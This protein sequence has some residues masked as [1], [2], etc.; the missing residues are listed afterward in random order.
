MRR[1]HFSSNRVGRR[2]VVRSVALIVCTVLLANIAIAVPLKAQAAATTTCNC[3]VWRLDDIQ[4]NF[5]DTVQ[6]A[7]IDHFIANHQ[8][9]GAVAIMNAVGN[10]TTI[11]NEVKKGL[12]NGTL[13]IGSHAWDHVD[14]TQLPAAT[15]QDTLQKSK[16]KMIQ[17]WGVTPNLF[18]PPFNAYNN[19]TLATLQSLGFKVIS[20]EF[21][22]E[23]PS[24]YDPNNPNASSNLIYKAIPNSDLKD[25]HGL[26]H[27]PQAIGFYTYGSS[28]NSTA[29][30]VKTPVTTI[31]SKIDSTIATY[32][33]A[34]VTLHPDEFAVNFENGVAQ[35]QVSATAMADLDTLFNYVNGKGYTSKTFSEVID[36]GSISPPPDTTPPSTPQ[37]ASPIDNFKAVIGSSSGGAL[38]TFGWNKATDPDSPNVSYELLVAS[39]SNFTTGSI[40]I[41]KTGLTVLSYTLAIKSESLPAGTYYWKV[42]ASDSSGNKSPYSAVRTLTVSSLIL[43]ATASPAGSTFSSPQTVTLKVSSSPPSNATSLTI[44]YTVDGSD[45]STTSGVQYTVPITVTTTSTLKF[46]AKDVSGVISPIA[47]ERYVINRSGGTVSSSGGGGGGGSS[48]GT[49]FTGGGGGGGGGGS[50][51][52]SVSVGGELFTYPD[53][54]FVQRPLDKIIFT[55]YGAVDIHNI[56]LG[57]VNSGQQV[58]ISTTFKNFQ[59]NPQD[60]VYI[61]EIQK[62]GYTYFIDW[63][64][65]HI[66]A[67]Q[68]DMV[69]RSWIPQ[70]P[71]N[72][73]IK[74]FVWDKLDQSPMALSEVGLSTISVVGSVH[75]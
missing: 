10:D 39:T 25:S 19:D 66:I 68:T 43:T 29:S 35:N 4:D 1:W 45:P 53:S 6:V 37:L 48:S 61:S 67:G 58:S 75:R 49:V 62:D 2:I 12:S 73:V 13:E 5:V 24:V 55:K 38:L 16:Q 63:Q 69:S 20:S 11:V 70:E 31:E 7:L 15:Q 54:H 60:Y 30:V 21:D 74:V 57:T 56:G 14:Y 28:E 3:V 72:Y 9:L 71:G 65:G 33:Y 27:L 52:G 41:D 40:K 8:K 42:A 32:G 34:V 36:G 22:L 47:T 59:N 46:V 18:I 51:G 64:P 50:S 17:L 44:Y 23:L 26:Y